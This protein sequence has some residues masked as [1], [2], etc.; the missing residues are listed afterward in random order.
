MKE[1]E[2][3]KREKLRSDVNSTYNLGMPRNLH[4][5][6]WPSFSR[7]ALFAPADFEFIC[8]FNSCFHLLLYVDHK[9]TK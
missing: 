3:I 6:S 8:K 2:T 5:C 4:I 1:I 7:F 9:G